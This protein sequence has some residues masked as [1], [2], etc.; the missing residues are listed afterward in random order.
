MI[1][2]PYI[3]CASFLS[4]FFPVYGAESMLTETQ[5]S[6]AFLLS[7]VVS[8]YL[9]PVL[10][11]VISKRM[12]TYRSMLFA[13]V[14]YASALVFFIVS[15]SILSCFIVV[16]MFAVADSFGLTAQ[17]VYFTNLPEVKKLGNGKAMSINTTV[18]NISSACGP[19]I[20]AY[21]FILGTEKGL[22]ILAAGF[23]LML[24]IFAAAHRI[25]EKKDK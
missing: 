8:I 21:I 1:N 23:V 3:I 2:F 11:E 13:S 6:L 10:S 16:A 12:G 14:I 24:T 7:G 22:M 25:I 15:P 4:Y 17:S 18:E 5:I 9:G 19:M 20:F